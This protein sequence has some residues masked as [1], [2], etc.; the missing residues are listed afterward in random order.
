MEAVEAG[1]RR[2]LKQGLQLLDAAPHLAAAAEASGEL[3]GQPLV[4]H[5]TAPRVHRH[6][7]AG[8][9]PYL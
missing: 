3:R 9:L 4:E 5:A 7:L 2:L 8:R 1:Q 6:F